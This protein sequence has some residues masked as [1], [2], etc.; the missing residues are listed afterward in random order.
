MLRPELSTFIAARQ[1]VRRRLTMPE[2]YLRD[3]HTDD[4]REEVRRIAVEVAD[5]LKY[6]NLPGDMDI[7][8][9]GY[10]RR[11]LRELGIRWC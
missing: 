2:D 7:L 6:R 3:L 11:L 1:E 8:V 4:K 5:R 10:D 9:D